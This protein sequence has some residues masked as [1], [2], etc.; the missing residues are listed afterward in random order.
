M[1]EIKYWITASD[2]RDASVTAILC[3]CFKYTFTVL[4]LPIKTPSQGEC[5]RFTGKQHTNACMHTS[6]CGFMLLVCNERGK[7]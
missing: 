4:V 6:Q 5:H 2:C 3:Q 1:T 7:G